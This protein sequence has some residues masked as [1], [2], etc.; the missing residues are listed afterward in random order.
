MGRFLTINPMTRKRWKR[1]RRMKRAT[2]SAWLLGIIVVLTLCADVLCNNIPLYVRVDGQ[3]AFPLFR[4]YPESTFIPEGRDVAPD[5]KQLRQHPVFTQ[6]NRNVIRFPLIPH[7]PRETL[8]EHSIRASRDMRLLLF[9]VPLVARFDV[10]PDLHI[11]RHV[12][13]DAMFSSVDGDLEGSHLSQKFPISEALR[14]AIERRLANQPS[15]LFEERVTLPEKGLDGVLTLT[16]WESRPSPPATVRL[17]L[18]AKGGPPIRRSTVTLDRE[19]GSAV[20]GDTALWASLNASCREK[21]TQTAGLARQGPVEAFSVHQGPFR[22]QAVFDTEVA[23]PHRPV[24]GHWLGLDVAGRDV[25]SRLV[26]G[27]RVSLVFSVL[28]V[29]ASMGIGIAIGAI[30]GYYGGTTDIVVQRLIEIWSAIPFL[31]VMIL[32]G[33]LFGASLWLLLFC[34]AIFHW[35]GISYYMRGEFLRLRGCAFVDAARS[36]GVRDSVIIF[37]HILPNA[38][39]PVI[40]FAPF[41]LVG[42]IAALAA[43]DYLGFGLPALTPSIGEL[44][45]QAQS[46]RDAWW[47]ILYPSLTLFIVML[48]GVFVGEGIR[49]AFDPRP[50]SNME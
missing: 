50:R 12:A 20:G 38:I 27:L 22:L 8:D 48:L 2:V 35:I 29:V 19:N 34:Y 6:S 25:L 14:N 30:Q 47:L 4:F 13:A 37:R 36:L 42:A 39:I 18:R 21:I 7:G 45:H 44:L 28:L 41:S 23:W 1:F 43:L 5:Y 17:T 24:R 31:Y 40:T 10:S 46:H 32:M 26:H 16:A 9:P 3:W 15:P 49:E 33:S 11:A